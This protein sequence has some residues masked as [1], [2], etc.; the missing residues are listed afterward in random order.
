MVNLTNLEAE[1]K[2]A[3]KKKEEE[4]IE[5]QIEVYEGQ[6]YQAREA[7]E[8]AQEKY[9]ATRRKLPKDIST[10][11]DYK[12]QDLQAQYI[13]ARV[14]APEQEKQVKEYRD[15]IKKQQKASKEIQVLDKELP[16]L[17]TSAVQEVESVKTGVE[18][19][20]KKV[21]EKYDAVIQ[22]KQ[23]TYDT[24]KARRAKQYADVEKTYQE[25]LAKTAYTDEALKKEISARGSRHFSPRRFSYEWGKQSQNYNKRA[26]EVKQS[27]E[28]SLRYEH[29]TLEGHNV[30][31]KVPPN[32]G[33]DVFKMINE[34]KHVDARDLHSGYCYVKVGVARRNL[35]S[36]MYGI[37]EYN[38][39]VSAGITAYKES[40][41]KRT[42]AKLRTSK[43]QL[44]SAV[45]QYRA[46]WANVAS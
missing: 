3:E 32:A 13:Q 41:R 46:H 21:E 29:Y 43:A 38:K 35:L 20:K 22:T 10:D 23:E 2:E 4:L 37:E 31:Q 39:Q 36:G 44:A 15:E 34:M 18:K 14:I 19:A 11:K 25:T 12:E 42:E 33:K 7:Y 45:Q 9:T 40:E 26:L 17:Y 1:I 27:A 5:A 6:N 8:K 30:G 24:E 16:Q 28:A